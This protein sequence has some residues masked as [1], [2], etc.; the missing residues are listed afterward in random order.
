M[1]SPPLSCLGC[2]SSRL[3]TP[4]LRRGGEEARPGVSVSPQNMLKAAW[5]GINVSIRDLVPILLPWD[6]SR[7]PDGV[8]RNL[9]LSAPSK[10]Q[11]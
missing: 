1:C 5:K 10:K 9:E 6:G 4:L 8:G 11:L 7:K 2:C 3:Q